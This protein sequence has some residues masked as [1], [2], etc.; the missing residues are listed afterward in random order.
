MSLAPTWLSGE[1]WRAPDSGIEGL[2]SAD[3]ALDIAR[4]AEAA[5]LDFVFRPDTSVLPVAP[6][7]QSF[8]FSSV[9]PTLLM[10]ALVRETRRIGMVTTIS[11]TFSHPYTAARQMMS[12]H[13]LSKGRAGWNVVTALQGHENFGLAEMPSSEARYDRAEE[14]TQVVARLWESFPSRALLVDRAAGRY[15]DTDMILPIDHRGAAFDVKGPLNVPQYPGPPIPLMQA[16][17]SARGID[18]AG[19]MADMVFGLTP[20]IGTA[21]DT[22]RQLTARATAH[23]RDPRA[24]RLLPGLSLYLGRTRAEARDLFMQT[25]VRVTRAQRIER[26][27]TATGLDLADWPEDRP[28]TPADLAAPPR[29]RAQYARLMQLIAADSPTLGELLNRPETLAAIHWQV[30]GT[31]EDACAEINRWFEA[32]A[33]DGFIAV[34]GGSA[35]SMELTLD[36]LVPRLAEAG[37]FRRA[38]AGETLADHLADGLD[39]PLPA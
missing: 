10:A 8:G 36:E 11:T 28:I 22:R 31:V 33:I 38:Y 15:A 26:L 25:H 16:G 1:G 4:R 27:E 12:L 23:R 32:G 2:Y 30:I 6:L 34:P 35:R 13:W 18:L 3:F 9:D 21:L 5:H 20:D 29:A 37:L 17:A 19:R 7:D 39:L 14:F 24:V